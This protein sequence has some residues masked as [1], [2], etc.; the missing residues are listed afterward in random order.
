MIPDC[1]AFRKEQSEANVS[2]MLFGIE[3]VI[4]LVVY[5]VASLIDEVKKET[6]VLTSCIS[7]Q[8]V[9]GETVSWESQI[10]HLVVTCEE[11]ISVILN[12]T[13]IR[14]PFLLVLSYYKTVI[15]FHSI[16]VLVEGSKGE[17]SY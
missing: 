15:V 2:V 8:G 12:F 4:S 11:I 6:S 13:V 3:I 16:K 10:E 14:L 7:I 5:R 17:R 1:Q 9:D